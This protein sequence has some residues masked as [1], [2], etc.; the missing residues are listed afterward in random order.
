[1][2]YPAGWIG[3]STAALLSA[4]AP[5]HAQDFRRGLSAY[6]IGD[7]AES[8]RQWRPLAERED[9]DAQEGLG[10][11]YFKGLGVAQDFVTA[12]SWFRRAAEQGQPE[13]QLLL[14][15][16]HYD[17]QGV[18]R[19]YV[20]AFKWCDLAQANGAAQAMPC[21]EA[22]AL[23]LSDAEMAESSRLVSEWFAQ[24]KQAGGR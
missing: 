6:N 18:T 24:H 1:M 2:R 20:L 21:R 7:Y 16:L 22:A 13:A 17:G 8:L 23:R 11:L 14:G 15:M 4:A 5:S 9:E 10:Y 3:L 12:A 19:S